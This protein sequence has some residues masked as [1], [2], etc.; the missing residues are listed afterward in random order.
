MANT[1]PFVLVTGAAGFAAEHLIPKLREQNFRVLG[2]DRKAQPSATV[3]EYLQIELEDLRSK[4]DKNMKI[5][6]VYHLAAAR[7]DWGVSDLEFERDNVLATKSIIDV[8]DTQALRVNKFTFV[9]SISVYPQDSSSALS[10]NIPPDP[11]NTYGKSKLKAESLLIDHATKNPEF[12][13]MIIRPTVLYGPSD[14]EKTGIARAID[15]N[16]YR[17]ID[18]IYTNRFAFLGRESVVKS[19]AYIKNFAEAITYL[20]P[21]TS[22]VQIINYADTPQKTTGEI[23]RLIRRG[24][25]KKGLGLKLPYRLSYFIAGIFDFLGPIVNVNFPI[26]RSRI[27]TFNRNTLINTNKLI[28][29]GYVQSISTEEG[30]S[31]TLQWYFAL[32]KNSKVKKG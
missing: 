9:S 32:T 3:D 21:N 14:P 10:E 2:V 4:L 29:T 20:Q 6:H 31:E 26:T 25:G 1:G 18:G 30:L 17:L 22:E 27:N 19:T 23:V 12:A 8:C 13:L 15:N 28:K 24:M 7:A 16:I 11:I 5:A